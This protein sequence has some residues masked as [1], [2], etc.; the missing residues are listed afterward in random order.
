MEK[1]K[2]VRK[3]DESNEQI[4]DRFTRFGDSFE[5]TH[6]FIRSSTISEHHNGVVRK[7]KNPKHP[8]SVVDRDP[9]LR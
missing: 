8:T 9:V 5:K 6:L 4:I 3:E 7:K 2:G 1:K